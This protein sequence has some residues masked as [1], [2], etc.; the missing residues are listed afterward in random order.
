MIRLGVNVPNFGP[1]TSF[2]ALADWA[3]FLEAN[4]F[5]TLVVSDH[6]APT[7]EVSALYPAAVPRPVRPAHLARRADGDPAP[8]HL[9]PRAAVPASAADRPDERD[10]G[11]G[12]RRPVRARRGQRLVAHRVRGARARLRRPWCDHRRVPRRGHAGLG[13]ADGGRR[14]TGPQPPGGR[15]PLWVGGAGRSADP[16]R[17]AARD[18]WHPINPR[19]DWLRDV[20]VPALAAASTALGLPPDLVPRIKA[21]LQAS[22]A[23]ADRPLGVGT[24]DQVV[25]DVA[26]LADLGAVEVV[27]D[28][29]PDTP[30]PRD[31][32]AEQRQ[33][34]E[35]KE[36]YG[37][38]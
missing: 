33:L 8:G 30:R 11:D 9:D 29:N 17:G 5:A 22:P 18:A 20:G 4:G 13:G 31:F 10:A 32:A 7:P 28:P 27:L 26:A 16:P 35:I 3:G 2:E 37:V 1:A 24:L 14:R 6:V 21:R 25:G 23:P 38:R 34:L 12:Q 15:L 19:L 36:A